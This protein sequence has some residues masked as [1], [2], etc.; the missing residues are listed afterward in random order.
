[1]YHD[2]IGASHESDLKAAQA[3]ADA[4]TISILHE[5]L[6]SDVDAVQQQLIFTLNTRLLIEQAKGVLAQLHSITPDEAFTLLRVHAKN[7][8]LAL[9]EVA[10]GLVNRT[11]TF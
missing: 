11:I 2:R 5:R 4:A 9:N 3:L 6:S 10:T 7:H 1:M 8:E